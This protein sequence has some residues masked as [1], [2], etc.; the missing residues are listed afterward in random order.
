MKFVLFLTLIKLKI[1]VEWK[2]KKVASYT[3]CLTS[4]GAVELAGYALDRKFDG[5]PG[6]KWHRRGQ[7]CH[8]QSMG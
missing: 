2:K 1:L 3:L 8:S 5:S 4:N 7:A 6:A